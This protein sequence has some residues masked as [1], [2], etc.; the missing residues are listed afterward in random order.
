MS[1]QM[2]SKLIKEDG[3]EVSIGERVYT[4]RGGLVEITDFQAPHKPS[5]TGRVYVKYADGS[6]REFFPDVVGCKIVS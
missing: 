2:K 1:I 4:F 5:S 6:T 3:S